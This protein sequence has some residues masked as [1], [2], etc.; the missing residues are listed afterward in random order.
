MSTYMC[1]GGYLYARI[2]VCVCAESVCGAC[3]LKGYV[4]EEVSE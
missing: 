2:G 1:V 4:C 3:V